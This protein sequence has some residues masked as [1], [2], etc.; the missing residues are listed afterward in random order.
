MR[1]LVTGAAGYVGRHIT[2]ALEREH[3]L[4]LADIQP[5]AGAARFVPLDLTDAAA[6]RRAVSGMDA[7]LHLATASGFEGAVED[8]AANR[9]RFAVN[10]EG[11]YNLLQAAAAAGVRR[12]V[13]TSSI[14][15]TWGYLSQGQEGQ[16]RTLIAG[17]APPKPVG[18]YAVT[19][20]LGENLCRHFA[21]SVGLSIV[22]LRIAKPVA[23]GDPYWQGRRIRPQTLPFPDL[24]QAY[25]KALTVPNIGFEV[26]TVVGDSS[27]PTW[28][29]SRAKQVLGYQPTIRLEEHG[30]ELGDVLEPVEF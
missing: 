23:L 21:E 27:R 26:V 4:V 9:L 18:T 10:V 16:P 22:C 28:D 13:H 7:V 30:F 3:E 6:V 19:K 5:I 20:A 25:A 15:V 29:L 2:P 24:A 11:T 1:V 12:V 17:D 14:M 8:D